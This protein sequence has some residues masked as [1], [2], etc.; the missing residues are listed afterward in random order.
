MQQI[1]INELKPHPRNNEFFDDI[2]GEK[3][4]ELLESIRKRIK[5]KKRGNIEPI[6]ITQDKVIVSGHQRVRAFKQLGIMDIAAEIR[7]YNSDDEILLDL[8]ESNIRRRGEIGGSAKK[9]GKRIKELERIYGI[10]NGGNRGN[11]YVEAEPSYSV[12]ATQ[13]DI[14]SQMGISVDTLQNYKLLAD[15]IPELEELVD[16]GIVTKTTAL[17]M[18]KN[19]STEEQKEL[20]STLPSDKKYTQTQM[21]AE[22]QKYKNRISELVQRGTKST[23][24]EIQ[25]DKPETIS[26]IRDLEKKLNKKTEENKKMSSVLIEKERMI[27]QAIG[28]S[29]NYQLTSHCSEIT[30]KMLNFVKEMSQY[31]Y[32]AESFNEIPNATRIEYEKCIKSV[33]KWA[34]RILETINDEKNII[35]M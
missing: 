32:M 7:I 19:L 34:D 17:A 30:L 33:K 12:L 27:N 9:V 1:N 13:S 25:V 31:D 5:E 20:I 8:L 2:T 4:E 35:E 26:K 6:I 23:I 3:W 22:I 10:H 29:T 16:T 28:S 11:Q 21:D 14:A 15:M 18:I 24:V